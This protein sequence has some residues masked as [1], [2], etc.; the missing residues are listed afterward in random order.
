MTFA[1]VEQFVYLYGIF[2]DPDRTM[3][4]SPET[5]DIIV[6]TNT[7]GEVRTIGSVLGFFS[8][9]R[10]LDSGEGNGLVCR[11]EQMPKFEERY[12]GRFIPFRMNGDEEGPVK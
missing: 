6:Y 12:A 9:G 2:Y 7:R 3:H 11:R 4:P 5:H 10:S 1:R 8:T